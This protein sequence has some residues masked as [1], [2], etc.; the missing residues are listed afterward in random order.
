MTYKYF[1]VK[2]VVV[3]PTDQEFRRRVSAREALEG[4]EVPDAAVL[5][6]KA[7]FVLP[8]FEETFFSAVR[9]TFPLCR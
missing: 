8:D 2:A 4:K 5:N 3:V 7:N 9:N 6:M 1:Q